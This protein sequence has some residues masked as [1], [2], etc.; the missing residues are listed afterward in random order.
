MLPFKHQGERVSPIVR[1]INFSYINGIICKIVMNDVRIVG[2][3]VE[4]EHLSVVF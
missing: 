3:D 2:L 4:L 1:E